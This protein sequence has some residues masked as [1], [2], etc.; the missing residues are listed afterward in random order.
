MRRA[1]AVVISS[2]ILAG[3]SASPTPETAS[4]VTRTDR[5]TP[6]GGDVIAGLGSHHHPIATS[7][8]QAQQMF[9]QGFVLVYAFNHEEAVRSFQRAAELDPGAVMPQWGLA[10]ALGPNYNLD[11]DDPRARQ[12]TDAI[13]RAK[14]LAAAGS[15]VE[16]DYVAAMAV[17]YSADPKADR[18]ALARRYADAMRALAA[19][20]PDDLDAV[21][22]Y[23]ESLMNLRPWKLWTLDGK[24]AEDTEQILQVLDRVLRRDPQHIGA[25]HYYIHSIEASPT[26]ERGLA[27]A[28]RL[29]TLAPA[30]G[31]LVHMPAHIL[32][33]TGDHA[34]AALANLAGANADRA[35]MPRTKPDSFY[36][37]AYYSHN[38]HFLVDSH[39]MQGRFGD[40]RQTANELAERLVPHA[41]MMPMIESM[42]IAP[43]NVLLRFGKY[44]D[45]IAVSAPPANRP[46]MTAWWR[47]T[48]GVAFARTGRIEQAAA[49][50]TALD[51]AVSQ[52]PATALFGGTGL[53]SATTVL[54]IAKAVLDA[55][56][57][58]TRG[59]TDT[60]VAHWQK[61]VAAADRLAYDEPPVWFYPLR[62]SL[63][64]ALLAANRAGDAERV[65]REDL[66]HHPRNPRALFGLRE[67]LRRQQKT[68][69]ADWVDRAFTAGWKNADAM[70]SIEGL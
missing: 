63:G 29:K 55:R 64:A 14:T 8:P 15:Q 49:E 50:R 66:V 47:F 35:Y 17:R 37:M 57:A 21:T 41:E 67:S 40:A 48:R 45:A 26:P 39:M 27:S 36:V 16:R 13:A 62:E 3:C 51:S 30:A 24:P 22:L 2:A 20:Y 6:E 56:I 25:N 42:A 9:D 53:E 28:E 65:F 12:A 69:D 19:R 32:A 38:L 11:I 18:A 1:I 44:D 5:G 10:W 68:A 54:E 70:L 59:A 7:N 61:A 52:V 60:A 33:R 34:G 4:N 31:H 43:M 23:A 46:V 58:Q